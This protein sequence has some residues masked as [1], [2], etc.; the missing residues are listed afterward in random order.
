MRY[1]LGQAAKA[2][3]KSKSTIQASIKKGRISAGQNDFGQYQIDPAELH[4][5]YPPHRPTEPKSEQDKTDRTVEYLAEIK[6][7]QDRLKAVSELKERIERECEDLREDRNHW[8]LQARALPAP[9]AS[10]QE[11]STP[12]RGFFKRLFG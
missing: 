3:G 10:A 5:V 12:K 6:S 11:T 9:E 2:T 1:T 4:R 8:R 7:L